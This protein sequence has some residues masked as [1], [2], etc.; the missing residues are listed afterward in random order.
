V[1]GRITKTGERYE[2]DKTY[3]PPCTTMLSHPDLKKYY[4]S[5][6]KYL[7]DIEVASKLIIE[8]ILKKENT[9]SI[10][11]NTQLLCEYILNYIAS[12]FFRYRNMGRNYSPIEII[13]IFASFAHTC[14]VSLNFIPQDKQEEMLQYFHAWN[15]ETPPGEFREMLMNMLES[16]YDHNNI[17]YIM[18]KTESFLSR[19]SSLWRTLSSLDY[20]GQQKENIVVAEKTQKIDSGPRK[21]GWTIID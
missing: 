21:T 3:I 9:I 2:V 10:A 8:K 6:G 17:R 20:V 4:E 19:F 11:Q 12:I 1:I 16:T 13:D 15:S 14:H 18:E 7:N 5:F